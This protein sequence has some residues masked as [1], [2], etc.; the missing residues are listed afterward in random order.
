M[1]YIRLLLFY[2]VI[3]QSCKFQCC[4]FSYPPNSGDK[5]VG[6]PINSAPLSCYGQ[7]T[8]PHTADPCIITLLASELVARCIITGIAGLL[9]DRN[10]H[11]WINHTSTDR[12]TKRTQHYTEAGLHDRLCII[13]GASVKYE[14]Q[15]S[16]TSA[17]TV[18]VSLNTKSIKTN[19]KYEFNKKII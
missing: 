5:Y 2:S 15:Q 3:F 17:L 18:Y 8:L 6:R 7:L 13:G 11:S 10:A 12:Q 19:K 16:A 4:K 14:Q 9:S 1:Q